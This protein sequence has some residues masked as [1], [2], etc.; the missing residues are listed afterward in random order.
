[1]SYLIPYITL[2]YDKSLK[3]Q[4]D[5]TVGYAVFKDALECTDSGLS[6]QN[7]INKMWLG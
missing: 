3:S 1:M 4:V 7:K 5:E 6:T 2:F